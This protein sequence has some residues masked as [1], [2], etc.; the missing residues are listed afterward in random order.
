[1][2]PHS[3]KPG[4]VSNVVVRRA[5]HLFWRFSR[6]MTLGVRAVLLDGGG[7]VYLIRHTYLPGWHLPG[8]GVEVGETALDA[9]TREVRE[10]A[11]LAIKGTPQLHGVFFNDKISRRDHVVV[12]VVRDFEVIGLKKPDR[13]IAEAGFFALDG[14]PADVTPATR[15]RLDE[16]LNGAASAATW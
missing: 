15:R 6:G 7:R 11:C 5:L 10:E 13:E 1:M 14:L 2:T 9:L 3:E 12:Y 8:G 16:I 4:L